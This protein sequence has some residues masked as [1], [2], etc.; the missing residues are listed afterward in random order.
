VV[1]LA[2]GAAAA[3]Y[4][5]PSLTAGPAHHPPRATGNHSSAAAT[6]SPS[7]TP[8][9]IGQAG[10]YTV[11]DQPFMF[12]E[13]ASAT[14]PRILSGLIRYPQPGTGT[15]AA[16]TG[17][18]PAGRFPLVVFAPGFLQCGIVYSDL[19]EQWASAGYVV[20]VVNFPN[21]N[22]HT[23]KPN[24][25]DLV[26]QP[27][28]VTAVINYVLKLSADPHSYLAGLIDPT[29]VAVAGHSDGGDTVAAM[30]ANP[31][32]G[33]QEL[34]YPDLKAVMVLSGAEWPA[35]KGPWFKSPTPPMLF[36]QGSNDKINPQDLSEQLYQSDTGT[37]YYLDLLGA[38]HLVPYEGDALPEPIVEKVTIAFLDQYLAGRGD[39][40]KAMA[41]AGD[42]PTESRLTIN[43]P[44]P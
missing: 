34:G 3:G 44:L 21:T 5:I 24:E 29:R 1:V 25:A 13:T 27:R 17:A 18:G 2:A 43:G 7:A 23:V 28:D 10:D 37:R 31:C 20:A 16:T 22:C 35:F 6:P 30:A 39:E 36:I 8:R 33:P 4:L 11:A 32:C 12:T 14:R 40:T 19:L 9:P 41:N 42:V 38:D 26:N 15:A